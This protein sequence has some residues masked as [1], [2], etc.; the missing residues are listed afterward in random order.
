[1]KKLAVLLLAVGALLSG[2][3]AYEVPPH[4]RGDRH[5][6]HRGEQRSDRDR[7]GVPDRVDRDRDG[8][9]V[10]NRQDRRP[11]DARRY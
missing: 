4:E 9:G 6:D 7:D 3:V 5:G 2:C 11:D 10:R 8:D 1:M